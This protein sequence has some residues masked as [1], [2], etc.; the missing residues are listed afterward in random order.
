MKLEDKTRRAISILKERES[1]AVAFSGGVDSSLVC[2]LAAE[3]L[4]DRAVAVIGLSPLDPKEDIVLARD[5]AEEIGIRLLEI[6]IP[7]MDDERFVS[8]PPERCYFCK[9]ALF[10]SISNLIN[11]MGIARIADGS[12]KD[13]LSDYRPGAAAK[14]EYE[15]ISPLLEAD[16]S[17]EE[18]REICRRRK[19]SVWDRPQMA[20][21]ASRIPYGTS[22]S[23]ELLESIAMAERYLRSKGFGQFRVRAHGP[24]ARVEIDPVDFQKAIINRLEI[25]EELRRAG[26]TYVT[27]DLAGFR[28]GSMNE[29]LK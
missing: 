12:T 19:L 26:F 4:G 10:G 23:K 28:S 8:N 21:L 20:C 25:I 3:A 27:L 11:E 18:V 13:D 6:E 5:I 14:D 24:I 7:Q 9:S 2:S 17:K 15:V 1:V 22:I 16:I 29:V